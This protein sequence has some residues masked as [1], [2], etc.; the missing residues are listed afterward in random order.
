MGLGV[1][2]FLRA[3]GGVQTNE[4]RQALLNQIMPPADKPT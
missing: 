2:H 4:A 3:G 1:H